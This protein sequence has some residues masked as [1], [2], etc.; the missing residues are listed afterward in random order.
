MNDTLFQDLGI[1]GNSVGGES[2]QL[3]LAV[4][5]AKTTEG[6]DRRIKQA[7]RIWK[8]QLLD[9]LN[10]IAPAHADRRRRP[11]PH[12]VQSQNGSLFEGR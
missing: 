12:S 5:D 4:I 7:D 1:T 2:H 9:Q 3:V 6:R 8:L 10:P 11:F